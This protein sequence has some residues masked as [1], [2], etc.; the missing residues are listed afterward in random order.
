[1]TSTSNKA[2]DLEVNQ[3]E[4]VETLAVSFSRLNEL[5]GVL[6]RIF[7]VYVLILLFLWDAK[8]CLLTLLDVASL[9]HK[10]GC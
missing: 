8:H 2:K 10:M 7:W 4:T 3:L 1:M 5:L 9:G 6:T